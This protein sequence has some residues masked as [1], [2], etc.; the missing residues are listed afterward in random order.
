ME[1]S[2]L[3]FAGMMLGQLV[4]TRGEVEKTDFM[5]TLYV[6]HPLSALWSLFFACYSGLLS[7]IHTKF[8]GSHFIWL[9]SSI[10]RGELKM[11]KDRIFQCILSSEC[12]LCKYC[13]RIDIA[14]LSSIYE[15]L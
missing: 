11:G 5:L 10:S 1:L 6:H 12:N 9:F 13:R 3:I 8:S 7:C 14:K 15:K 4:H 2:R